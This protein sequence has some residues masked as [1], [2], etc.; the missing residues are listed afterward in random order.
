MKVMVGHLLGYGF[1]KMRGAG[2]KAVVGKKPMQ[3]PE[4]VRETVGI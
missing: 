1:E 2:G 4:A 3:D